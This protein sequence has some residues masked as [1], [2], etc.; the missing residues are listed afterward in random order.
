M[1]SVIGKPRPCVQE[2]GKRAFSLLELLVAITILSVGIV[3]VLQALSVSSRVAALSFD[4]VNANFLAENKMQEW[5]FKEK[6]GFLSKEPPAAEDKIG[7][8]TWQYALNNL[9]PDL[10]LYHLNFNLSWERAKRQE[11]IN[12]NTYL[13]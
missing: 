2:R 9:E 5:E 12:L 11:K 1:T 3:T 13:R 8:F 6:R 10:K 7:K 4:L